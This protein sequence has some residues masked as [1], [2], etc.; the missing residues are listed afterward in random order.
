MEPGQQR[1]GRLDGRGVQRQVGRHPLEHRQ[2][3]AAR[4]AVR[5]V[6]GEQAVGPFGVL[7]RE[8]P[9][10]VS[11]EQ[12]FDRFVGLRPQLNPPGRAPGGAS[13]WPP[14]SWSSRC[15][16]GMPSSSAIWTCVYAWKIRHLEHLSL[17]W[18]ER[19][20]GLADLPAAD[21]DERVVHDILRRVFAGQRLEVRRTLGSFAEPFLATDRIDRPM[22]H[23]GQEERPERTPR[24]IERLGGPP[25]RHERVV[26]HVLGQHLLTRQAIRQPVGRRR[27]AVVEGVE[28]ARGRP[29]TAAGAAP[30]R[31]RRRSPCRSSCI[32]GSRGARRTIAIRRAGS[33][34]GMRVVLYSRAG[35]HLCDAARD[36]LLAERSRTPFEL[37]EVDV[38]GR[39][40]SGARVRH[41]DP[42]GGDRRPGAVRVPGGSRGAAR[43]R[44]RDLSPGDRPSRL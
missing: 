22:V 4:R 20:E 12:L 31:R 43:H 38:A 19:R 8:A 16:C 24:G 37:V 10:D 42:R 34:G 36:V 41:P 6:L 28:R 15:R 9:Q 21:L 11:G 40:R 1:L 32:T 26:D 18:G 30:G 2:R 44:A 35:C 3:V 25:E 29:R 5:H 27:V 13:A 33:I 39:R 14:G 17:W 7:A 23:Q